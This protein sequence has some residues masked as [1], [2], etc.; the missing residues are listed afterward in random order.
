MISSLFK[1]EKI[2]SFVLWTFFSL[3]FVRFVSVFFFSFETSLAYT[4]SL[5]CIYSILSFSYYFIN[6][7]RFHFQ[8]NY[9]QYIV[10]NLLFSILAS[11][12]SYL[13]FR[14]V[15]LGEDHFP[16]SFYIAL[17]VT[18]FILGSLLFPFTQIKKREI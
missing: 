15:M 12:F 11:L 7:K 1:K 3:S 16:Y 6:K 18:N 9:A 17:T 2:I 4:V 14:L 10:Y 13:Y 8:L 5:L